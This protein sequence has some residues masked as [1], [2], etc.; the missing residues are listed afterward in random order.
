MLYEH[1]TRLITFC[2]SLVFI[3]GSCAG[4]GHQPVV[5]QK[6]EVNGSHDAGGQTSYSV[7]VTM[8]PQEPMTY[9]SFDSSII[10]PLPVTK[11]AAKSV[12]YEVEDLTALGD[13]YDPTL[14]LMNMTTDPIYHLGVFEPDWERDTGN[15]E[16]AACVYRFPLTGY[17]PAANQTIGFEWAD[18]PASWDDFFVGVADYSNGQWRWYEGP[19]DCVLTVDS[20]VDLLSPS[21]D[22]LV[23]VAM[24]GTSTASLLELQVGADEIRSTGLDPMTPQPGVYSPLA[25]GDTLP[26]AF[27]LSPECTPINDQQSWPACTAFGVGDGAFNYELNHIY[28]SAGYNLGWVPVSTVNRTSPKHLYI[29]SG[30]LQG[31]HPPNPG[32]NGGSPVPMYGRRLDLMSTGLITNGVASE[33]NAP[34]DLKYEK[35]WGS[36]ADAD[37]ALLTI[38]GWDHVYSAWY[39]FGSIQDLKIL[40]ALHRKPVVMQQPLDSAFHHYAP[41]TV[42]EYTGPLTGYHA[43]MLVGYDDAKGA[44]KVRNSWGVDWGEAGYCW[45]DYSNFDGTVEDVE[46]LT[47]DVAFNTEVAERFC[48]MQPYVTAPEFD[49]SDGWFGDAVRVKWA[50][51]PYA[52]AYEIYRDDQSTPIVTFET[53]APEYPTD[54]IWWDESLSDTEVHTYWMRARRDEQWSPFNIDGGYLGIAG[55]GPWYQYRGNRKLNCRSSEV[56]PSDNTVRHSYLSVGSMRCRDAVFTATGMG[57]YAG[58]NR[59]FSFS[60]DGGEV[61]ND[62]YNTGNAFAQSPAVGLDGAVYSIDYGSGTKVKAYTPDLSFSWDYSVGPY[63][64]STSLT[65]APDGTVY[66]C[67]GS[68]YAI[69]P[70]GSKKWTV[71]GV[72][73]GTPAV[74]DDG[75][76]YVRDGDEL[77]AL[78]SDGTERW[79]FDTNQPGGNYLD[80]P[81]IGDDGRIYLLAEYDGLLYAID[82]LDPEEQDPPG[83]DPIPDVAWTYPIGV[84]EGWLRGPAVDAEGNTFFTYTK[85]GYDA[86][87]VSVDSDGSYRWHYAEPGAYYIGYPSVDGAGNVQCCWAA[88]VDAGPTYLYSFDSEGTERW[89]IED[90]RGLGWHCPMNRDGSIW[91]MMLKSTSG[92]ASVIGPPL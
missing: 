21:G 9:S 82:D 13:E 66:F 3:L 51:S 41:G 6:T 67:D 5:D 4:N 32:W 49:A 72:G 37:A 25:G 73:T 27:D 87:L 8:Q 60:I 48:G 65:I 36:E 81:A 92:K 70:D 55:Q 24:I 43:L 16:L 84:T 23:A 22:L 14:P 28:G 29:I 17:E 50:E 30:E 52:T 78:N 83:I 75:S 86:T 80:D 34:Y 79:R 40:L 69:K 68:F 62:S 46:C 31:F 90:W 7:A 56:S 57:I 15:Y 35:N 85:P 74:A 20:L 58:S 71:A 76:I 91:M 77:L 33:W 42:W 39:G 59:F 10:G 64:P 53:S 44:F 88:D 45:I 63:T 26:T 47:I 89:V 19:S 61:E 1:R 18:E 38:D 2:A 11:G 12:S 54:Q